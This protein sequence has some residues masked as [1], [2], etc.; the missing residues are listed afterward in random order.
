MGLLSFS[1]FDWLK[2][3]FFPC[4]SAGPAA[5]IE[6]ESKQDLWTIDQQTKEYQVKADDQTLLALWSER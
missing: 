6:E 4:A 3:A 2:A 5:K 1:F